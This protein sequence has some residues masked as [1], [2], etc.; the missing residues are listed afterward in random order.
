MNGVTQDPIAKT[1]QQFFESSALNDS[2][3]GQIAKSIINR[4]LTDYV[5]ANKTDGSSTQANA[6]FAKFSRKWS[7]YILRDLSRIKIAENEKKVMLALALASVYT[8]AISDDQNK[9]V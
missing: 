4:T 5:L 8:Q 2:L 6:V 9:Q 3:L 1:L 7:K